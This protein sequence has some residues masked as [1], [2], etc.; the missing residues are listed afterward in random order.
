MC[1]VFQPEDIV[2]SFEA[3][4]ANDPCSP[5]TWNR[6]RPSV[7]CS[8]KFT[9]METLK[10]RQYIKNDIT[11]LGAKFEELWRV[12][13]EPSG[14]LVEKMFISFHW[15]AWHWSKRAPQISMSLSRC[16]FDSQMRKSRAYSDSSH[17]SIW[18]SPSIRRHNPGFIQKKIVLIIIISLPINFTPSIFVPCD[19][20]VRGT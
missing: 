9:M 18:P 10:T 8:F 11:Y 17:C 19:L 3:F 7:N 5:S 1:S 16:T 2:H 12:Q 14:Y 20:Y 6:K 4:S 15:Q 13:S